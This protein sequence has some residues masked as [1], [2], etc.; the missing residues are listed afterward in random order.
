MVQQP[1]EPGYLGTIYFNFISYCYS[2]TYIQIQISIVMKSM[3]V[4]TN[5]LCILML[6]LDIK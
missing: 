5:I 1:N 6:T 2:F 3:K 4:I